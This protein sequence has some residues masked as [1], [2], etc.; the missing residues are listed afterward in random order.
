MVL[1]LKKL[2]KQQ[3]SKIKE[4]KQIR[5]LR[6]VAKLLA[7]GY[8][9]NQ[10]LKVMSWDKDLAAIA[11]EVSRD[12]IDGLLLDQSLKRLNFHYVITSYLY[13]SRSKDHLEISIEKSVD[14]LEMRMKYKN[15]LQ[16][17]LRYPFILLFIFF[18]LLLFIK[19]SILPTFID[20]IQSHGESSSTSTL[21]LLFLDF[22][23]QLFIILLFI[24]SCFALVWLR[25]KER[26]S[27]GLKL[28]IYEKIPLFRT[29]IKVQ[30]TYLFATHV[31]TLLEVGMPM[32]DVLHQLI[33]Q[34][35]LN[36][37]SYYAE[38]MI[39]ELNEGHSLVYLLQQ[40]PFID[41]QIAQIYQ[42]NLNA[43]TLSKDLQTYADMLMDTIQLKVTKYIEYVQPS[44][45]AVF[46]CFIVFIYVTLMWPM[47]E[48]VKTI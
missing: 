8:S 26:F 12:L 3:K 46:A 4:E 2:M 10:S 39:D 7:S 40:L 32:K 48:L 27:L 28:K 14:L 24:F 23:T 37:I 22:S 17:V 19:Y 47:F 35:D 42:Q 36:I 44:L 6:Q 41:E 25:L 45:L 15:K 9:L 31:S 1:Y 5:F 13:F 34:K 38:L 20:M 33:E 11:S 16:S 18:I 30:T 43:S 21:L 29:Y